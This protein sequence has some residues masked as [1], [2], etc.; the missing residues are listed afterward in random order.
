MASTG[1]GKTTQIPQLILDNFTAKGKGAECNIVCTQ[2]RRLAAI[3]VAQRVANERNESL[4]RSVGYQVR[5]EAK[6]PE[7]DGS[8]LFCTTGIFLKKLHVD[9]D[10][11][12]ST[13]FLGSITH[14]LV[15]EVHERDIDVDLLLFVLRRHMQMMRQA[16][17][18]GFKIVLM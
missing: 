17:K 18:P 8:I 13:S 2:P 14:V 4:G 16:G 1:S 10:S 7:P 6:P 5:F 15:D 3:S 11:A 9:G 12:S